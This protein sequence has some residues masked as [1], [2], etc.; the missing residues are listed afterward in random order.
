VGTLRVPH[1]L[2]SAGTVRRRLLTELASRGLP[3][4]L[5]DDVA[6]VVSELV[7]NAVRHGSPLPDGG[8]LVEW[9]LDGAVLVLEV[10][11]G[12]GGPEGLARDEGR[13]PRV[14]LSAEGGRGL[15]IV[16]TVAA[17][18]GATGRD[19]VTCVRAELVVPAAGR[20]YAQA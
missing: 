9:Q 19:G 11:D 15:S 14:P 8:L 6:L 7:G 2:P 5:L 16:S 4:G 12:G 18:W 17:R 10:F 13:L 3:S 1:E 20:S